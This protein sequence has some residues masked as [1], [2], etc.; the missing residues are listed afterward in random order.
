[1]PKIVD[2]DQY[3]KEL[4]TKSFDLF[5]EKGYATVT[6][7]QIAQ[8]LGVSTGTLYHYFP[9][10]E[11]LFEQLMDELTERD[12]LQIAAALEGTTTI[13]ERITAVF[14]FLEANQDYYFKQALALAD[15]YRHQQADHSENQ[16]LRRVFDRTFKQVEQEIS[17][18]FGI[19]DPELVTFLICFSDGIIWQKIYGCEVDFIKQGE[20]LAA[21]VTTYLDQRKGCHRKAG[22]KGM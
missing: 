20:I 19:A 15:F 14:Q 11:A 7:R 17:H 22:Q 13:A 3:R 4:L 10:K 2:H 12:I 8:A 21:M 18:L 6:M 9:S 5:A 16:V 1:M